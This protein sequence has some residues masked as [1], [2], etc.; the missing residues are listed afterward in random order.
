MTIEAAGTPQRIE[1]A[2]ADDLRDVVHQAVASLAGGGIVVLPFEAAPLAVA[3]ALS[4]AAVQRLSHA[5]PSKT[6]ASVATTR[7]VLVVRSADEAIDWVGRPPEPFARFA[8]RAWPG[9]VALVV[10]PA[11]EADRPT[12]LERLPGEVRSAV[13]SDGT[14][15]LI[16]PGPGLLREIVRL[17]S[18]PVVA[19]E[20]DATATAPSGPGSSADLTIEPE[21]WP[22]GRGLTF[23]RIQ[24]GGWTLLEPG[25]LDAKTVETYACAAWLFVCTGNTCRSPMAEAL[26]KALL[27]KRLGCAIDELPR[28]GHLIL[29]AG[30]SAYDGMP[31]ASHA[32][33]IVST[34]GGSLDSHASRR[35]T[36]ALLRRADLVV[37][38]SSE[39]ID[40]VL[41]IAPDLAERVRMLHP[42]GLDVADP[43]GQDRDV[44]LETACE[45]ERYLERLLDDMG[46]GRA[47][48][49]G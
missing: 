13:A 18:G 1:L 14:V 28:R 37:G 38:L 19:I 20:L 16:S 42:E 21:G 31:A 15:S 10:E 11:P 2:K 29:S 6:E 49:R 25:R 46:V 48:K 32:V 30:V 5:K 44:Y 9:P 43:V 36:S 24:R 39:H 33:E 12:L 8:R 26:C 22:A 35:A 7:P 41:E 3:S 34:R 27:A 45:I 17:V 4:P 47:S 40:A 23:V